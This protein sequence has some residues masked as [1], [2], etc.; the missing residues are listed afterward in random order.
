MTHDPRAQTRV[1]QSIGNANERETG[2]TLKPLSAMA[3]SDRI[4]HF[5]TP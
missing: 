4:A 2:D 1:V 3:K 5:I